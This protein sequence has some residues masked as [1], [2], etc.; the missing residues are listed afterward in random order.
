[1]PITL[2]DRINLWIRESIMLKLLSI[3]FLILILLIPTSWIQ[4]LMEERQLRMEEASSEVANKW[5]GNQTVS[6]PILVLPYKYYE[7]IERDGEVRQIERTE[8]AYFLP[9]DL[10]IKSTVDPKTLNRG[11]FDVVVYNA[12]V[13][14][15]GRFSAPNLT[16][17]NIEPDQVVWR[18]AHLLIGI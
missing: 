12:T 3:G 9:D 16:A 2:F 14:M 6:G 18:D 15:E 4:S 17:L 13:K 8:K 1:Q 10:K 7:Q 5:A 11:I